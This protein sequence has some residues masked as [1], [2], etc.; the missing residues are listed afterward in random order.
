MNT[1]L[2]VSISAVTPS[3]ISTGMGDRG[4]VQIPVQKIYLGM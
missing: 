1:R 4:H 3:P 2:V